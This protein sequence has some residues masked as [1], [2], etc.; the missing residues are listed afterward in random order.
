[1]RH[2]CTRSFVDVPIAYLLSKL[3]QDSGNTSGFVLTFLRV[4]SFLQTHDSNIS[5][6][7]GTLLHRSSEQPIGKFWAI[8]TL[9][10]GDTKHGA[11]VKTVPLDFRS[12]CQKT[13][14]VPQKQKR[15]RGH[16]PDKHR[17]KL[18]RIS[19]PNKNFK[20][21]LSILGPVLL[22]RILF[23]VCKCR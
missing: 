22:R 12:L 4:V 23:L 16:S 15:K 19:M 17:R 14:L 1:M 9:A 7:L 3:R 6:F 2:L 21:P 13:Q 20:D 10:Y 5:I 8:A 11:Y 18:I